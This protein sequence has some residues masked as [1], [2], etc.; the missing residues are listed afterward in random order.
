MKIMLTAEGFFDKILTAQDQR[1]I[2]VKPN[3]IGG[4]PKN[5]HTNITM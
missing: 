4:N 5:A 2:L 1:N 3:Y